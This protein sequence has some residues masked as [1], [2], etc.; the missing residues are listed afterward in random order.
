MLRKWSE[1]PCDRANRCGAFFNNTQF[2]ILILN[3]EATNLN[4]KF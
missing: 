1:T 2:L 4:S 3:R